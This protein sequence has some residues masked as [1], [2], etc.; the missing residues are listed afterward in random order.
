MKCI[1]LWLPV[2][3]WAG[4]IFF[5]S[6]QPE[7]KSDLPQSWDFFFRKIAHMIEYGILT[8]LLFRAFKGY[9]LN[10]RKSLILAIIFSFLYAI[11]DEYHQSFILGR[12]GTARDVAIDSIGIIAA[13]L[14]IKRKK[15][16]KR[17]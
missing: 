17:Q 7:L 1:K 12:E 16:N 10:A 13:S 6:S 4:V 8:Y 15:L 2:L 14:W 11:S 3:I 9:N 5:L